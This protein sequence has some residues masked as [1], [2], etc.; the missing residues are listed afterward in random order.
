MVSPAGHPVSRKVPRI[1]SA[2][3]IQEGGA[4]KSLAIL[5]KQESSRLYSAP[6]AWS[7]A[8]PPVP[9]C[10]LSLPFILVD[11]KS[12]PQETSHVP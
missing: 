3:V 2:P 4:H 10:F 12:S 8:S 7:A 5:A 11:P 9:P 1:A 6:D